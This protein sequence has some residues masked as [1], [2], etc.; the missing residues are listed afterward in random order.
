ML[1][2]ATLFGMTQ[3]SP[4]LYTLTPRAARRAQ[5]AERDQASASSQPAGP[6]PPE[7]S[8]RCDIL[9]MLTNLSISEV[10]MH[11]SV[12]E[13]LMFTALF[14]AKLKCFSS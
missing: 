12:T 9:F 4:S 1:T 13:W 2:M 3:P 8:S 14:D 11:L 10:E 6:A 5:A 7:P